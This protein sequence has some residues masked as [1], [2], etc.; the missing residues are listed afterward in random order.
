MSLNAVWGGLRNDPWSYAPRD[1]SSCPVTSSSVERLST[2]VVLE[3]SGSTSGRIDGRPKPE[4]AREVTSDVLAQVLAGQS[5]GPMAYLRRYGT[6]YEVDKSLP[7][8]GTDS[9]GLY[10]SHC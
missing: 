8:P 6:Y 1:R 10:I 4:V 5:L 2:I 3:G 7:R 9:I